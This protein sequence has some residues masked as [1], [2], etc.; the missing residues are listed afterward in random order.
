MHGLAQVEE[1]VMARQ[2]EK[3]LLKTHFPC[4]HFR[5][6]QFHYFCI[7]DESGCIVK[8]KYIEHFSNFGHN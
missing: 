1:A 6:T 5:S 2:E 4:I 8:A 3:I 7:W